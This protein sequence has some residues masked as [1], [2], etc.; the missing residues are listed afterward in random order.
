MGIRT[1]K[2][3]AKAM[4]D[5]SKKPYN[6]NSKSDP[7]FFTQQAK[8]E[9]SD[10]EDDYDEEEDDDYASYASSSSATVDS[11][12]EWNTQRLRARRVIIFDEKSA[13]RVNKVK[14]SKSYGYDKSKNDS[15]ER[16]YIDDEIAR[17]SEK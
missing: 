8:N 17:I 2:E 13:L 9:I 16:N 1:G 10:D 6:T 5:K 11:D 4:K 3:I 14:K 12:V 15:S 7:E